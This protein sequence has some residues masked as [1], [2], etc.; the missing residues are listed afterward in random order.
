M[1]ELKGCIKSLPG[2]LFFGV[3][4]HYT[5]NAS[6]CVKNPNEISS[7]I[8]LDE[9]GQTLNNY[10]RA[11]SCSLIN[12]QCMREGYSTHF[13]CLCVCVSLSTL[14]ATLI[15]SANNG[16]QWTANDI[17]FT[18]KKRKTCKS[19]PSIQKQLSKLIALY[20]TSYGHAHLL[21]FKVHFKGK[22][23]QWE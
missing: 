11:W 3:G 19:A 16:H 17:L 6:L 5:K 20:R 22:C 23:M 18:L 21:K 7:S 1:E 2:S 9:L 4:K 10:H 12:P 13:V 15:Y 14:E 8:V